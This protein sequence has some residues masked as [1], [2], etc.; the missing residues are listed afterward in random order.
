MITSIQSWLPPKKI[1]HSAIPSAP[2]LPIVKADLRNEKSVFMTIVAAVICAILSI[3]ATAVCAILTEIGS[4]TGAVVSTVESVLSAFG[5][6]RL[7]TF[8]RD[9]VTFEA[10]AG[11]HW[12]LTKQRAQGRVLVIGDTTEFVFGK[13]RQIAGI[14]ETGN[15]SGQGFL[16][17][18]A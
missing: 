7:L 13:D 10:I 14:G 3:V 15:G 9:E 1:R 5:Q 16:L 8:D 2:K 11:P 12:K 18:N 4:V 17:H 6:H